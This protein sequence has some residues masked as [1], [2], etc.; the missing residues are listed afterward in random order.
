MQNSRMAPREGEIHGVGK[1]GARE[2]EG[3][4][5]ADIDNIPE[6]ASVH[7]D[8][9]MD[10]GG[11]DP[12]QDM[13]DPAGDAEIP[14]RTFTRE[15]WSARLPG[16]IVELHGSTGFPALDRVSFRR[17]LH[18]QLLMVLSSDVCLSSTTS[19]STCVV[20]GTRRAARP[21]SMAFS[22]VGAVMV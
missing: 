17:F 4:I 20:L 16:A 2:T 10:G 21:S 5:F 15:E 11:R 14:V 19:T 8:A 7:L 12:G 22:S 13:T 9:I 1:L 3:P 6:V 18:F